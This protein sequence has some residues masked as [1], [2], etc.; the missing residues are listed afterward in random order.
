[1][2]NRSPGRDSL[3]DR[4]VVG[5]AMGALTTV[6]GAASA[7]MTADFLAEHNDDAGTRA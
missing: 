6:V 1:M 2:A 4:F 3:L 7:G 5:V